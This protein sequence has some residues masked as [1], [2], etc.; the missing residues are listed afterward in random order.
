MD[1]KSFPAKWTIYQ[2]KE[3]LENLIEFLNKNGKRETALCNSLKNLIK[4]E[5]I[6]YPLPKKGASSSSQVIEDE[7]QEREQTDDL[8]AN[9]MEYESIYQPE[10]DYLKGKGRINRNLHLLEIFRDRIHKTPLI[11]RATSNC[12]LQ[13]LLDLELEFSN[14]LKTR[15]CRWIGSHP[16]YY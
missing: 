2:S 1:N 13:L 6:E 3:N 11:E 5:Y 8:M 16:T 12:L 4:E 15:K 10:E 9:L 7:L 14:Y